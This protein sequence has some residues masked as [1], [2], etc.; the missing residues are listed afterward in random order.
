MAQEIQ[1]L[2]QAQVPLQTTQQPV[3][4]SLQAP[5]PS[6]TNARIAGSIRFMGSPLVNDSIETP[7]GDL[8]RIVGRRQAGRKAIA[9][10]KQ[11]ATTQIPLESTGELDLPAWDDRLVMVAGLV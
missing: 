4:P 5:S 10:P 3:E 11:L 2:P 1:A 7:V 6:R 9:H 8:L